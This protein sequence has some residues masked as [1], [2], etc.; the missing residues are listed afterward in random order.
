MRSALTLLCLL[1]I[2][3]PARADW[4]GAPLMHAVLRED[5]PGPAR[6][7]I[8]ALSRAGG[9]VAVLT[10]PRTAL[11]HADPAVLADPAV[12]AWIARTDVGPVDEAALAGAPADVIRSAAVWGELLRQR[13]EARVAAADRHP[14]HA[15]PRVSDARHVPVRLP[16]MPALRD[17]PTHIPYGAQYYDTSTFCAGTTAVG[18]WLLEAAGSTYDW[19]VAEE[20]QTLAGVQSG[21]AWW[22]T[23]GGV[24]A[25]LSFVME[26]H[27]GV[28][29]SGVPI[30]HPQSDEQIW[31]G[32]ALA[33]AGWAGA[34]AFER[35]F[36]Y[37]NSIRDA[38]QTNWCVSYFIC[39]SDPAVNQG[40]FL[41]GGY[42]WSYYGGPWVWMSRYSSWAF[43]AANYYEAVPEHELGHTF[44]A[45][46]EYD[47]VQQWSGYMNWNDS[48]GT[49]VTCLMNRNVES[50]MCT[51]SRRQVGWHDLDLDGIMAPLDVAPTAAL[52]HYPWTPASPPAPTWTGRAAVNTLDNLNPSGWPYSPPHDITIAVIDAVECRIDGG[53]W[54]PAVPVDGAFDAY[55]EDYAW[56]SPPLP[57]GTYTV[58]ARAH[59]SAGVW[60]TVFGTDTI[61]V[62]GSAVDAPAV[63]AGA[64]GL[65]VSPNPAR[66]EVRFSWRVPHGPATLTVFDAAGRRVMT[67][68]LP[69]AAGH[70]TW[71]GRDA[72]GAAL[73]AGVYLVRL[74]ADR[75]SETRRLVLVR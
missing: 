69:E 55:G 62:S 64:I 38:Y 31:I 65:A 10:P 5:A 16:A 72:G 60:S 20:N 37:N 49:L 25:D 59:T 54:S 17:A 12:K 28:P 3:A 35:C 26:S 11:I 9:H 15:D 47:G 1:A 45:T 68:A 19:T 43:N 6:A 23:H 63:A 32:E 27:T 13:A 53:P 34:N 50:V 7:F 66:D 30:E 75:R 41:G 33:N 48:P 42:A 67:R 52:D 18:V 14:A 57:D 61:V 2:T 73:G 29:V 56:T 58:E 70:A 74:D 4:T 21:L 71:N 44:Y 24:M 22:V 46:D 40:L 36:A 51:P 39:D 8:E